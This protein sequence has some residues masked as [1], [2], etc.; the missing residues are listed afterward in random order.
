M[1][2]MG[3]IVI[4]RRSSFKTLFLSLLPIGASLSV[5]RLRPRQ[6]QSTFPS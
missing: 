4:V 5:M 2:S 3:H 1:T 6:R